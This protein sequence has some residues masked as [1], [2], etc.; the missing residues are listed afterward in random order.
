M[1]LIGRM[2][3][4]CHTSN[5]IDV[6]D[7]RRVSQATAQGIYFDD[8]GDYDYT[9]HLRTIGDSTEAVFLEAPQREEKPKKSSGGDLMFKED[10]KERQVIELPADA[11]PSNIERDIGAMANVTGL[12]GGLQPDMD[13]R[14]REVLEALEDDEYADG[15]V[16]EDFFDELN[17]EGDPYIPEEEDYEEYEEEMEDGSYNW[18]AAFRK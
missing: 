16:D 10:Q 6:E 8:V 7:H 18:E 13:P 2:G 1:R 14:L 9:Q 15:Q 4:C 17:A 5:D 3:C 12:E 11:M